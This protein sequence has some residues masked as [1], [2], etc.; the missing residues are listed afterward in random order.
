VGGYAA[1]QETV[2]YQ[3]KSK[4]LSPPKERKRNKMARAYKCDGCGSLIE[5]PTVARSSCK[6]DTKLFYAHVVVTHGERKAGNNKERPDLCLN[7]LGQIV[8]NTV[9]ILTEE[10]PNAHFPN[11]SNLR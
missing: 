11:Q 2:S 4:N 5:K 1:L 6:L 7:C 10:E 9:L 8:K 3:L